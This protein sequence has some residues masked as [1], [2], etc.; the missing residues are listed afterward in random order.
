MHA[1]SRPSPTMYLNGKDRAHNRQCASC[2]SCRVGYSSP[3]RWRK[4]LSSTLATTWFRWSTDTGTRAR[5]TWSNCF[6]SHVLYQR[7]SA[8]ER[9]R[10]HSGREIKLNILVMYG[11]QEG[12]RCCCWREGSRGWTGFKASL[13]ACFT[14]LCCLARSLP[15]ARAMDELIL[16]TSAFAWTEKGG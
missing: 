3:P 14:W 2:L 15:G 12:E 5:Q 9:K 6:K 13:A 16:C 8:S 4:N 10:L 1:Y 7:L 11:K